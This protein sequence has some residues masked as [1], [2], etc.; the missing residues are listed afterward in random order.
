MRSVAEHFC[1]KPDGLRVISCHLGAGASI[2]A[3]EDGR[4]VDTSMGITPLEGLVMASRVGAD[5]SEERSRVRLLVIRADEERS[6]AR[7]AATLLGPS[8]V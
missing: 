4:S 6:M 1:T 2:A 7:E 3:I 5:I 8:S